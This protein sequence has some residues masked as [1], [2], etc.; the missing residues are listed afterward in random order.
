[1]L[2]LFLLISTTQLIISLYPHTY[3]Y[4]SSVDFYNQ[5]PSS[6]QLDA[7]V[8]KKPNI[9]LTSLKWLDLPQNKFTEKLSS[10]GV[11][12]S[13]KVNLMKSLPYQFSAED[14]V[15]AKKP[16]SIVFEPFTWLAMNHLPLITTILTKK[17]FYLDLVMI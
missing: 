13:N 3:T 10:F 4:S 5:Q 8:P 2:P 6:Q 15:N 9:T 17:R 16:T 12:M 7:L 14:S 1:M 11:K